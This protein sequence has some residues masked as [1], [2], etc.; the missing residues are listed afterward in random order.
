V[1]HFIIGEYN[2]AEPRH[3]IGCTAVEGA[4]SSDSAPTCA[5]RLARE[6]LL[7][8]HSSHAAE[9]NRSHLIPKDQETLARINI[10]DP[11]LAAGEPFLPMSM[12]TWQQATIMAQMMQARN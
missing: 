4:S 2:M 1:Y 11:T 3:S 9:L 8:V 12:S 7:D 6:R 5:S 10:T